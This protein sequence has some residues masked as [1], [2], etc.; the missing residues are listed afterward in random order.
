MKNITKTLLAIAFMIGT[1]AGAQEIK[2]D[3]EKQGDLIKGTYYYEDGSVKQKGTY[4]NGKLHGEWISYGQDGKKNAIA[5]YQEGIKTGKWFFWHDD[6]LMEVDYNDNK[7][8]EV[9]K[10]KSAEALAQYR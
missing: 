3:F 9:R 8:A 7:I 10:Y 1:M 4:K 2:P 5:Q 6:L